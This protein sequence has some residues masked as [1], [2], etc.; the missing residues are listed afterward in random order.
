MLSD[1]IAGAQWVLDHKDQCGIRVANF[2]LN[3]GSAGSFRWDPLDKAVEKLWFNG[4]VVVVAAG[5]YGTGDVAS[6]VKYAPANDPFVITVGASDTNAT[7]TAADDFAA[8]WSA[9][10]YTFDGF[11]KP[12]IAAPGR[13]MDGP[14]P[15]GSQLLQ[16]HRSARPPPATCGSQGASMA[17]PVVAGAGPAAVLAQHPLGRPIRSR[18]ALLASTA[19]LPD[20]FTAG[21]SLGRGVPASRRRGDERRSPQPERRSRPVRDPR[22]R[23][24]RFELRRRHVGHR[25]RGTSVIRGQRVLG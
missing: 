6:G 24:G 10:G 4:I 1:V 25:G 7:Q 23:D 8:P 11:Q 21:G 19:A 15:D 20:G 12:D 14:V 3:A 9:W 16:L 2:S 13:V 17:A 18:G 22:S 5:N